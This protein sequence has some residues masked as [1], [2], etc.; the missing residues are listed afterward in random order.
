MADGPRLAT[1]VI[2]KS[3]FSLSG[4]LDAGE[5]L[6]TQISRELA[7]RKYCTF[8]KIPTNPF[9]NQQ[10]DI[11]TEHCS[12]SMVTRQVADIVT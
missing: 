6:L 3:K 11:K 1:L 2:Y 4:L 10:R 12:G 5:V 9:S 8:L 7:G